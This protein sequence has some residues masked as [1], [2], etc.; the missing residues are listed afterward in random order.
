M[1][2]HYDVMICIYYEASITLEVESNEVNE[3]THMM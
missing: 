1:E 2:Q 3:T